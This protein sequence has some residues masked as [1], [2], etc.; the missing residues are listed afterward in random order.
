MSDV[1]PLH[2]GNLLW[3]PRAENVLRIVGPIVVAVAALVMLGRSWAKWP[4]VLVDFGQQLYLPW[5]LAEGQRLYADL[6]Y[7]HGPLAQYLNALWFRLLGTGLW[8]LVTTNLVVLTL[9]LVLQYRLLLR[10]SSAL[11]ATVACVVFAVLFA[12]AQYV[13]IGNYNYV[14]PYEHSATYGML[15]SVA[16]LWF[17][18][19]FLDR[20]RRADLVASGLCLGL[21]FLTKAEVFL[22]VGAAVAT[23]LAAAMWARP[24]ERGRTARNAAVLAAASLVPVITAWALLSH[25][26]PTGQA[27]VGVLGPWPTVLDGEVARLPF[28]RLGMGTLAIGPSLLELVVWVAWYAVLF[29]PA[30]YFAWRLRRRGRLTGLVTGTVFVAVAAMMLL[31]SGSIPWDRA[32]LPLPV[33]MVAAAAAPLVTLAGTRRTG[34]GTRELMQLSMVVFAFVLLFKMILNA[35]VYHYGFFLA[36]PATLM[37]VV[38]AVD[39]IPRA[40]CRR[41][42]CGGIFGAVTLAVLLAAIVGHVRM[43]GVYFERKTYTVAGGRDAF[44]ADVRA[45]AVTEALSM[46]GRYIG[47][48]QTLA[49]LPEGVML[50]YLARRVN[51]TPY[52]KLMPPE[53]IAFGEQDVLQAFADDPPDFIMLVHKD[54]SEFGARFFGRDYGRRIF[55]WIHA[56]YE[57]VLVIGHPPLRDERFGMML[58]RRKAS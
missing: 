39:W 17:L 8:T 57:P 1:E 14:T 55:E 36:M 46:I 11:G 6:A 15:S 24:A 13:G 21:T 29:G 54:T 9:L 27:L 50:N 40:I 45:V 33:A 49:V 12:F 22:A 3:S 28:Y 32:L 37:L 43:M 30:F 48:R 38:V 52:N 4:D 35:R 53:L 41:R 23:A 7:F 31:F 19:R 34:A 51:P 20:G 5:R 10:V 25:T 47:P 18:A 2:R 42:G 16:T 44:L 58:M 26:M 56:G